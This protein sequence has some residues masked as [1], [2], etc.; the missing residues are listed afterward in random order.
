[1]DEANR[2]IERLKKVVISP[3]WASDGGAQ[4]SAIEVI[5]KYGV[6][7]IP[8]LIEI[9]E[10][11]TEPARQTTL[12]LINKLQNS[13]TTISGKTLGSPMDRRA[14]PTKT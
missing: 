4:I 10:R 13:K 14:E 7:A 6:I 5:A 8:A 3:R 9:S 12:D 11:V 2:E 1:L